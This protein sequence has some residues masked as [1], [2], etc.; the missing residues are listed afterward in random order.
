VNWQYVIRD[1]D[2][3]IGENEAGLHQAHSTRQRVFDQEAAKKLIELLRKRSNIFTEAHYWRVGEAVR[4]IGRPCLT[5]EIEK[6]LD[7]HYPESNN[8]NVFDLDDA[9][10]ADTT[11]LRRA[12]P[13]KIGEE[14]GQQGT[15]YGH[16]NVRDQLRRYLNDKIVRCAREA[17]LA[18]NL[19]VHGDCTSRSRMRRR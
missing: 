9:K 15:R 1:V 10:V 18:G 13:D 17:M 4:A 16:G 7:E 2:E 19:I 12:L 14:F 6:W 11:D 3:A 5:E 8:S